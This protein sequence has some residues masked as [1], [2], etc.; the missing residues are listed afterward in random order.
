VNLVFSEP[1]RWMPWGVDRQ[2]HLLVQ[3]RRLLPDRYYYFDHPRFGVI[4]RIE[5][6]D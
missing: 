3:S 6:M 4:A 2:H 5:P 1:R